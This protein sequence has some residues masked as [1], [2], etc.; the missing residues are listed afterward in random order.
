MWEFSG[1]F[2]RK[3]VRSIFV[4]FW[5]LKIMSIHPSSLLTPLDSSVSSCLVSPGSEI[6]TTLTRRIRSTRGSGGSPP[7]TPTSPTCTASAATA[8]AWA[9]RPASTR[10]PRP[11]P[12]PPCPSTCEWTENKN[13][14]FLDFVFPPTSDSSLSSFLRNHTALFGGNPRYENVPLIGRGSPPP[15]V[16]WAPEAKSFLWRHVEPFKRQI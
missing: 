7:R 13:V 5:I 12:T 10:P 9:A 2:R 8:A 11:S 14:W 4:S 3:R 6:T 16:R 15:S 1:K